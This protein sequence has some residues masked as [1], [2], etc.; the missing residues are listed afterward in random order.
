VTGR[1]VPPGQ[2]RGPVILFTRERFTEELAWT[3]LAPLL[4]GW[5]IRICPPAEVTA[6]VD[7][8]D[9][10]CPFGSR[11]DRAVLEAGHFGLVHQFGV[12]LEK[13]DIALATELGVWVARVPADAGANADSVAEIAVLHML[14]LMRRLGDARAALTGRR[15]ESRPTGRSL[16][17]ATIAVI[18][19][20]A[21]GTA[22]SV[23]LLSFGTRLLGVRAHPERGC[24]DGLERVTGP[25][26]L[27]AVLG[28]A[29]VVICC[30]MLDV[31]VGTLFG[32]A[33]FAAMK[34][35][36]V[37]V[38][39][40]RGGL[41][42]EAALLAALESGHLGGAGLDVYVTEPADPDS[43]LLRHPRVLATPHVGALTETMFRRTSEAFAANV[44]RWAA[45]EPPRWAA[46]S[47]AT[48][49]QGAAS[50]RD[51][52]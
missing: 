42:D 11:V 4:P 46:N 29:D 38:N 43:A 24:P 21:V 15:W 45:G 34:P 22:V 10:I 51:T 8:A 28:Q 17:G 31:S 7:G 19:L 35:G 47:P 16:L 33:E 2:H 37:F 20:G 9:V 40:A 18:G 48:Q 52:P 23:R 14:A 6:H 36:A 5:T 12:G 3:E 32:P 13:V 49:R 44:L 27:A 50:R 41:V 25:D 26:E 1:V 30:A 39:V